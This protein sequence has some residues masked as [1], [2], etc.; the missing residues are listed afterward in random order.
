MTSV[1]GADLAAELDALLARRPEL[2][3]SKI[4]LLLRNKR[5][6]IEEIR[7]AIK[8]LPSTVAKVRAFI[9]A[10]PAEALLLTSEE[11]SRINSDSARRG[12]DKRCATIRRDAVSQARRILDGDTS[13]K[14]NA[15]ISAAV[16]DLKA[17][18]QN[19]ARLADPVERAKLKLQRAG[20]RPVVCA[21]IIGGPEG[22]FVVGRRRVTKDE[23]LRLAEGVAA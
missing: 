15:V 12:V 13:I 11:L 3:K 4:G 1:T 22:L 7:S 5:N 17:Q 21:T 8:P 6:G 14:R 20:Y 2:S 9:A 18:R 16:R 23:L 19:E 10:P